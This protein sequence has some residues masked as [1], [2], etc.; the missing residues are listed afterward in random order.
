[1]EEHKCPRNYV[2]SSKE[3]DS[4]TES[5]STKIYERGMIVAYVLDDDDSLM[6]EKLE[7]YNT[8]VM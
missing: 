7:H 8:T 5:T 2:G 6:K 4:I 3:V 1:M